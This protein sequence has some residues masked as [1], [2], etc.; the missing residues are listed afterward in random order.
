[1][2]QDTFANRLKKAI[3]IN[4]YKQIDVVNKTANKI[5][6]SLL[7]KYLNGVSEAGNDKLSILAEA[8]NVNEVW[9]M[10]YDVPM[11]ETSMI[12]NAKENDNNFSELDVLWNK[13]KKYLTEDDKE[14]MKFLFEKRM[15]DIDK[16]RENN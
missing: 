15:R 8:L 11:N 6:K 13:Y 4:D 5:D 3:E 7:N 14:T 10:G 2:K 16:Q 1:M 9:L 12:D